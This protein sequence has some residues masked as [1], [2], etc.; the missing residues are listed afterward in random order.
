LTFSSK[1]ASNPLL[2][3]LVS[4]RPAK[5]ATVLL[6]IASG[7]AFVVAW[8]NE[9]RLKGLTDYLLSDAGLSNVIYWCI[10]N[11]HD[12]APKI[13][14]TKRMI[15]SNILDIGHPYDKSPIF[16]SIKSLLRVRVTPQ[17]AQQTAEAQLSELTARSVIK[18]E[19]IKGI[20]PLYVIDSARAREI[21]SDRYEHY[22]PRHW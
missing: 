10:N 13:E 1:L 21:V 20:E 7:T 5:A 12:E 6:L 17:F 2:A 19:G 22:H 14:L 15:A 4:S 9:Q 8:I 3:S 18:R 16:R 11:G